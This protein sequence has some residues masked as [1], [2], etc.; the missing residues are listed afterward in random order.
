MEKDRVA[1]SAAL[2]MP[3]QT[4]NITGERERDLKGSTVLND[5]DVR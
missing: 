4:D 1:S 5:G 2:I 3:S